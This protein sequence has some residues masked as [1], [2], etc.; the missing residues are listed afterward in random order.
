MILFLLDN[1]PRDVLMAETKR[2][3]GDVETGVFGHVRMF[4]MGTSGEGLAAGP[5]PRHDGK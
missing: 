1:V 5:I 4:S 3:L 2:E